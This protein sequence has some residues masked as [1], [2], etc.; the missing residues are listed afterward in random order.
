MWAAPRSLPRELNLV[1]KYAVPG[2]VSCHHLLKSGHWWAGMEGE[3]STGQGSV[4]SPHM[5]SS[6]GGVTVGIPWARGHEGAVCALSLVG[7][8]GSVF[9][10]GACAQ[11]GLGLLVPSHAFLLGW[12]GLLVTCWPLTPSIESFLHTAFQVMGQTHHPKYFIGCSTCPLLCNNRPPPKK[13]KTWKHKP[14]IRYDLSRFCGLPE[15]SCL[16]SLMRLH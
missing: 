6:P 16:G 11:R 13:S 3:A 7:A 5:R 2:W 8:V 14:A 15:H 4:L 12:S 10:G 9:Q 1:L